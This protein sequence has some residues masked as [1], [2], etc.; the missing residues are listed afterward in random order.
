MANATCFETLF[1]DGLKNEEM[2]LNG[3]GLGLE[4]LTERAR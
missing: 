1:V 3:S 4:K 2:R